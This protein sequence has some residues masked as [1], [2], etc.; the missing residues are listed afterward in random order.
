MTGLVKQVKSVRM[1]KIERLGLVS[2]SREEEEEEREIE[3]E[4]EKERERER[5]R[6]KERKR[7]RARAREQNWEVSAHLAGLRPPA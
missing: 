4:S 6:A 3:S 2:S 1:S 7:Q 5:E